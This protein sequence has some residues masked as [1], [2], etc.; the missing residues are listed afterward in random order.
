MIQ[1]LRA[2]GGQATFAELYREVWK[3]QDCKW[4]AKDPSASIRAIVQNREEIFRVRPGLW[5][6]RSRQ[7][8]LGLSEYGSDAAQ[9]SQEIEE[10]HSFYQGMLVVLGNLRR[11]GTFVPNQDKNRLFRDKKLKE[12]RSLEIIP[13]YSHDD[14]VSRSK[15]ID[16]VWFNNRNMPHSFFEVEHSTDIQN[17]LLKFCDLQDFHARFVIVADDSK[18]ASFESR[19]KQRAFELIKNRVDFLGYKFLVRDYEHEVLRSGEEFA[20]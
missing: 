2:L 3:I 10:G 11:F 7:T 17:S 19:M 9:S 20:I 8:T 18:R 4:G 15:T 14:L 13:H 1:A 6:L 5:A 16:V 12:L